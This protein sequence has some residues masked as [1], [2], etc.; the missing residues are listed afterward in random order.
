MKKIKKKINNSQKIKLTNYFIIN[1]KI[2]NYYNNINKF[3]FIN[4][5]FSIY[6]N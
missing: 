2:H 1:I 4:N 3:F 5:Q 6:I